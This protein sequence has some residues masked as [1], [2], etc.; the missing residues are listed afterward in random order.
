MAP[1]ETILLQ[2]A[3]AV[4]TVSL[5]RPEVRNAF[6]GRMIAELTD[7]FSALAGRRDVRAVI[8]RGSGPSFSAGADVGWMRTSLDFS[9]D[10]NLADALRLSDMLATID[11]L[12][13]PVVAAVHGAALG[14]GMGLLAACDIVIA[15]EGTIFGFTEAKLGIVPAAI[16]RFVLPKIGQS[17]ARALYLTAERFGPDLARE[18][19][20]VHWIAGRNDLDTVVGQKIEDVLTS[21]PVAVVEAKALIAASAGLDQESMRGHT[22]EL[23]ATLRTSPEGQEGLRAF[24]EKRAPGWRESS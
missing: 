1:Y 13:K 10:D 19:G 16:S 11:S 2:E 23:I 14:G 8:L 5:D 3:G 18:I 22:A 20:L 7:V 17:W 12:P 9:S 24:L 4:A 15:A 21:G 6:N